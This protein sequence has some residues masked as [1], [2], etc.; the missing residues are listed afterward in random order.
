MILRREHFHSLSKQCLSEQLMF[1]FK[2]EVKQENDELC[3]CDT[4]VS[5]NYIADDYLSQRLF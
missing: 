2:E 3:K 1:L 5:L 4:E